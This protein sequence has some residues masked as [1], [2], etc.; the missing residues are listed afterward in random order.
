[1]MP[2]LGTRHE[3]SPPPVEVRPGAVRVNGREAPLPLLNAPHQTL[4]AKSGYVVASAVDSQRLWV[5][6]T[7]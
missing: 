3:E 4:V 5:L 7:P 2:C 1:M 6:D